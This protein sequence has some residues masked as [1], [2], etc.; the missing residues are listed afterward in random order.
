[1]SG[2]LGDLGAV[3]Q[4]GEKIECDGGMGMTRSG[5]DSLSLQCYA[6]MEPGC[7]IRACPS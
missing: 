1:M 4:F 7:G 6:D 3:T 5:L 2:H